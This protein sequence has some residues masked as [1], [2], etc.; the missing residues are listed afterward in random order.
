MV[1]YFALP[2][3]SGTTFEAAVQLAK[4][5]ISENGFGI[6]TDIDMAATL[7]QKTGADIGSYR[8]LGACNPAAAEQALRIEPAIGVLLPC[9]VVIRQ[10]NGELEVLA[11]DPGTLGG[12]S[13]NE[14]LAALAVSIRK[15]LEGVMASIARATRRRETEAQVAAHVPQAASGGD[16][17][18]H[19][20]SFSLR[21]ASLADRFNKT[22]SLSPAE[23]AS[24]TRLQPAMLS[25]LQHDIDALNS[26]FRHIVSYLDT[27]QRKAYATRHLG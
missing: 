18:G 2:L 17:D 14:E 8:I 4:T 13:G 12:F 25:E 24:P 3:P 21:L 20:R 5:A 9:N 6:V 19:L 23:A 7:K 10:N 15:Q 22:G 1:C 16:L 11:A 27:Q 26:N